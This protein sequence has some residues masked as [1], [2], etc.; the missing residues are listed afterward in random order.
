MTTLPLAIGQPTPGRVCV[1]DANPQ[2]LAALADILRETGEYI[3]HEASRATSAQRLL[4]DETPD[5]IVIAIQ[6]P[7]GRKLLRTAVTMTPPVP[8]VIIVEYSTV[9]Q[10]VIAMGLGVVDFVIR[11]ID[12]NDLRAAIDHALERK[13][14][15]SPVSASFVKE[16]GFGELLGV[17]RSMQTV[18]DQIRRAAPF[19]STVFITGESGTGK[20]LVA[21]AIHSLSPVSSG[22][23]IAVNCSA[24]PRDLVESMFFGHEKGSF[25]GAT[26]NRQGFFESADNGTLFL[27]EVG[28]LSMRAQTKLLRVLE[29]QKVRRLGAIRALDVNVRVVAASNTNLPDAIRDG[30]F[31]E[32]LFYRLNVIPIV[33]PPLRA[34]KADI[35]L[36]VRVFADRFAE[37]NGVAHIEIPEYC[38][39]LMAEYDWPG[40]VR[41]LKNVAERLVIRASD[42]ASEINID[43]VAEIMP[44]SGVPSG[45]SLERDR[46]FGQRTLEEHERKLILD[47]LVYTGGNRTHAAEIL[48]I[49]LRTLQRKLKQYAA[50]E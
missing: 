14:M 3:V 43:V 47:T 35:P 2:Q 20:E 37:Q 28:D 38:L 21:G 26:R 4:R 41:E 50:D 7:G 40:N 13:R 17:S 19:R 39:E 42:G 12:A 23:F 1:A 9:K 15:L 31:R 33:V 29:E 46:E 8:V 25:T 36:L 48:G 45:L 44:N 6:M 5:A 16:T 22:P 10:A 24:L 30:R 32:D 11:P 34:R 18:Y 49:S 27:D